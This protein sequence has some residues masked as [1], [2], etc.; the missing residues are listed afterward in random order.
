MVKT[1]C[2]SERVPKSHAIGKI[3]INLGGQLGY[4]HFSRATFQ[5]GPKGAAV[6]LATKKRLRKRTD[7]TCECLEVRRLLAADLTAHWRAQDLVETVADGTVPAAWVDAVSQTQATAVGQPVLSHHALGGRAGVEFDTSDGIDAFRVISSESPLRSATDFTLTVVF[8]TSAS[9]VGGNGDWFENTALIDA[10]AIGLSFD[11]GISMNEAGQVSAGLG[12][13]FGQAPTNLY[14]TE[15]G[16]NDGQTHLAVLSRS[17]NQMS[18]Q[19]DNGDAISV[20]GPD[21]ALSSL[22]LFV[23]AQK[24]GEPGY[25]GFI[26]EVRVYDAALTADEHASLYAEFLSQYN[27][28]APIAEADAYSLQEDPILFVVN[29][30]DGVLAND[31][32]AESDPMTARLVTG[33]QHGTLTLNEDGS[34][35]Y[36]PESDFFGVDTFTYSAVDFRPSGVVTVELIVEP[37]RDGPVTAADSYK[38]VPAE[39]LSVDAS[40]GVLANDTNRD[41]VDLQVVI[42]RDVEHGNLTVNTD[43]SFIYDPQGFAGT[44]TFTY[45]V[46]DGTE[47]SSP[48]TVTLIVNTPPSPATD[49]Y[50]IDEDTLLSI[51]AQAGVLAN[52]VDLDGNALTVELVSDTFNGTLG[53]QADG[54]FV[55]SPN[56]DYFGPD[57]FTYRITDGIDVSDETTVALE[58]HAVNDAPATQIDRYFA[59]PLQPL[60]VPVERGVLANDDDVDGPQLTASLEALPANGSVEL[61]ADGSFRYVADPGFIGT[62]QFTYVARDS[63]L[64]SSVTTVEITV[65]SRPVIINEL[66]T[67]NA[68]GLTTRVRSS[69]EGEYLGDPETPDWIELRN[70][71]SAPVDIGGMYLTDDEDDLTLWRIPDGTE[72]PSDGYLIIFASGHHVL[73]TSLDEQATLHTNFSLSSDGEYLALVGSDGSIIQEFDPSYG[74]Q[75]L[76]VSYGR[77]DDNYRYFPEPTPGAPNEGGLEAL[78]AD[79]SFSIDRGYFTEPFELTITADTPGA[80]LVYTLDGETPTLSQGTQVPSASDDLSPTATLT[81]D[82]TTT[83][84]VAAFKNGYVSTNVDTQSYFFVDD[85]IAQPRL[86]D[87]VTEDP[88]WGPLMRDSILSIP[89]VS[90]VLEDRISQREVTTSVELIFPDGTD[91]FQVDAGVEHFG[92]HSINSPKKNMR[93]SFKAIYGDAKLNY[94]LF[95]GDAVSE[96]D[97]LILRTGSHDN[98]F[99]THPAGGRGHYLRNRWAFDRQ[100]EMGHLAPHGRYVQVF[101]NGEYAGMHHLMERPNADFMASYL[102]GES[103]EYDALNAGTP[104]DG[105]STAWRSLQQNDVIDDYEQVKQYLDVVNYADYMLL[106]F[107]SGNDWDWNHNQNW[108]GARKREDGAGYIFFAWDSDVMLRTTATANVINK[109]GPGN[110]WNTR[111][112]MKQHDEFLMLMADRAHKWFFNGGMLTNERLRADIGRMAE[113]I[114]LPV[115]AET[116]RWGRTYRYGPDT[117]EDSVQWMLDRFAPEGRSGRTEET[118]RQLRRAGIY[119][120]LDAPEFTVDGMRQHGGDIASN[121]ELRILADEGTVYYTLDG[122]DPRLPGGAIHPDAIVYDGN[123]VPLSHEVHIRA[124]TYTNVWSALSETN[125]SVGVI[126]ADET[127]LRISEVHYH[128]ADPTDEERAAGHTDGDDFEFIELVNISDATVDL[129]QVALRRLTV[130]E[131]EQ[132]VDFSFGETDYDKLGP[133]EFVIVVEDL[134]A[135]TARYGAGL[136]VAGQWTGGLSNRQEQVTLQ[137]GDDLI[138]QFSYQDSWHPSTDGVGRS[139]EIADPAADL[140]TWSHSDGW[141]PSSEVHGSPGA[142]G[143]VNDIAGDSNRDGRFDSSDLVMV[144]VAGEY[145]DNIPNNST[146]EE[147]DWNADGDFSTTDLV[148]ALQAGHYN[149][150]AAASRALSLERIAAAMTR[151][152]IHNHRRR[153]GESFDEQRNPIHARPMHLELLKADRIFAQWHAYDHAETEL[154]DDESTDRDL[155]LRDNS[156]IAG[157][158]CGK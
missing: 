84:R 79:T 132:G 137:A 61:N 117:W 53:I 87:D 65:S 56:R 59:V 42:D 131:D 97:Q 133:G 57:Q 99:W 154:I 82:Q 9:S 115:I 33:A 120:S 10:N 25:T 4:S 95:G 68:S 5:N 142:A 1:I 8:S 127:N 106:Q 67:D 123:A 100:L 139:L 143:E 118:L 110:L 55:Y 22:D 41:L 75:A 138:H 21:S 30:A 129:S 58:V 122:T 50:D 85:I 92:G 157:S 109:G 47:L 54:S 17:G 113:S 28:H 74:R 12:G 121:A 43:G 146:W 15:A 149:D 3:R 32:D 151:L 130:A 140:A 155:E 51:T 91:G 112:G 76:D 78:V 27:N 114:R 77:I 19:I 80:T 72:I 62:D 96:F 94:D 44:S 70:L 111:G 45:Q 145:E 23:G 29:A 147:G 18:L 158:F 38:A 102:G 125:F 31:K 52:D 134:A 6:F 66:M 126:P 119:P 101:I 34:F 135:F 13:G 86:W 90:L 36:V 63:L 89:T 150:G 26:G 107:Y 81:I 64:Q 71:V 156:F 153:H 124:R 48:E 128:P 104:I 60:E 73:D 7:L 46:N 16:L 2:N 148:F 49:E 141:R 11:W 37:V 93:L 152:P 88:T 69:I 24:S 144:F 39:V 116:A 14:S 40:A 136:P 105:D 103:Y 98:W 83:V 108:A 20:A 35:V